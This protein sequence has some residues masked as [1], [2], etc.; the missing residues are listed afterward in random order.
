MAIKGKKKTQRGPV[1]ELERL[2]RHAAAL[3]ASYASNRAVHERLRESEELYRAV[4]ENVA[5]GIAITVGTERVFVNS[6]YL[7]IHGVSDVSEVLGRPLDQFVSPEDQ[8]G[9]RRRVLARQR[10]EV[11]DGLAEYK[12]LRPDGQMRIVQASVVT[13]KYKGRPAALS[14][15]RDITAVK[16]A[17]TEI[18]RLNR[19]LQERILDLRN[20]NDELGAFNSTVS[21][22][23]RTPL[24]IIDGF[25]RRIAEKYGDGLD[26]KVLDYVGRIRAGVGKM[27]QLIDDL[28]A[29][30]RLGRSV[31]QRAPIAVR[32]MVESIVD[33]LLPVY[34]GGDVAIS[35]LPPCEGDRPMVRRAFTNLISNALKFSS[36]VPSRLVEVG[37]ERQGAENLYFVKD[38]GA[39]FDMRHKDRLFNV[40]Q[41]LHTEEEFEGT[42]MGLAIV[43]R[44]VSLHGG[45][46]WADGFVGQG[47]TFF[48][49][50]PSGG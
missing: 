42:G 39:G 35:D 28:L 7:A 41:R 5:D 26:A 43:K 23:L 50:L 46:A 44:I 2:R 4:V 21:H 9:V 20:A 6:A 38:N 12:I 37:G 15:L 49:T 25:S 31:L 24:M 40:F 14:V 29:Y 32:D 36:R 3:E 11:L 34:P 18:V 22:D 47:A 30:A 45:H 13:T 33:E 8:E 16:K 27:G 1:S 10:G 19:E 17:E 48:I